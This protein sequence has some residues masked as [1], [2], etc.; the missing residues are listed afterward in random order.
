VEA[1]RTA[2]KGSG[3]ARGINGLDGRVGEI[4]GKGGRR[5]AMAG[6]AEDGTGPRPVCRCG[7]IQKIMHTAR[8]RNGSVLIVRDREAFT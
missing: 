8:Y 4:A 1:L 2:G 5:G 7:Q 3:L 6:T